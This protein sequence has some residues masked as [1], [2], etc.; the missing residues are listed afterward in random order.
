MTDGSWEVHVYL[1]REAKSWGQLNRQAGR[2]MSGV[3]DSKL[4]GVPCQ[5][6]GTVRSCKPAVAL[7]R[8]GT[9]HVGGLYPLGEERGR[10]V[11]PCIFSPTGWV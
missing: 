10:F 5:P 4:G 1:P 3:V 6:P 9:F 8:P 7:V 2:D 11:V